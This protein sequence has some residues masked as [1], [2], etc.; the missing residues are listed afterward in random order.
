MQYVGRAPEALTRTEN[1]SEGVLIVDSH[2][3]TTD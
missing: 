1:P 2:R 3:L